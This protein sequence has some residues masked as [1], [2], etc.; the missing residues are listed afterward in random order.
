M[1][2]FHDADLPAKWSTAELADRLHHDQPETD[3]FV[4]R[5]L[6]A[7]IATAGADNTDPRTTMVDLARALDSLTT[8]VTA[9]IAP[10]L[11]DAGEQSAADYTTTIADLHAATRGVDNLTD[12]F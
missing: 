4:L 6:A 3:A 10:H 1:R 9:L 5:I 2:T 8:A 7:R 12:W 11:D